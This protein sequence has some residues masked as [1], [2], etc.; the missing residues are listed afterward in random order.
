[1]GENQPPPRQRLEFGVWNS[2]VVDHNVIGTMGTIVVPPLSPG[3]KFVEKNISH[4]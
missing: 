1:M 2:Y 3:L 4:C